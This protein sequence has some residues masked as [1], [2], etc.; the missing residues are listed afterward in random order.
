MVCCMGIMQQS[1]AQKT[2][3]QP[4][5][6][7][8]YF[9]LD[10]RLTLD[11]LT[12][13]VHRLSGMRFSFNSSKVKGSKEIH[14]PKGDYSFT[15]LLEQIRKT[16]SLYYSFYQGYV[17]FQDNPPRKGTTP[18]AATTQKRTPPAPAPRPKPVPVSPVSQAGSAKQ[19]QSLAQQT[20]EP[21]DTAAVSK[22]QVTHPNDPMNAVDTVAAQTPALMQSMPPAKDSAIIKDTTFPKQVQSPAGD[23]KNNN[24]LL[25]VH[26]G[27]Q[28][29]VHLPVQGI[30]YYLTGMDGQPAP[31]QALLPGFWLSYAIR[32]KGEW[33]LQ[34]SPFATYQAGQKILASERTSLPPPDSFTVKRETLL[35]KSRGIAMG[36]QYNHR[37]DEH[38]FVGGGVQLQWQQKALIRKTEV[39][40][41]DG[42]IR[43]DTLGGISRSSADWSNLAASF[44]TAKLELGYR[45]GKMETGILFQ[46]P[47]NSMISENSLR[48]LNGMVF[49]R[50]RIR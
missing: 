15:Q 29:N 30:A 22:P 10:G 32:D 24:L 25:G 21:R 35:I 28:W 48:P 31:W 47:I 36:I 7:R 33:M 5:A 3:Q 18:V 50:W 13:Y 20:V 39:R 43:A 14:F 27:L 12:R 8:G 40:V 46:L 34:I 6:Y 37:L 19:P 1:I 41:S 38:W 4:S 2:M 42:A 26:L 45:A 49:L 44:L 9:H 11:S 17:I 16:T 23:N